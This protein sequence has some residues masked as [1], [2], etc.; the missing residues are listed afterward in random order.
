MLQGKPGPVPGFHG[1]CSR[2]EE[3]TTYGSR[4]PGALQWRDCAFGSGAEFIYKQ[5]ISAVDALRVVLS[6]CLPRTPAVQDTQASPSDGLNWLQLWLRCSA[7][8]CGC[9]VMHG[10]PCP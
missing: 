2:S 9:T 3:D 10:S 8:A 5:R 4:Q 7:S 1:G 6:A